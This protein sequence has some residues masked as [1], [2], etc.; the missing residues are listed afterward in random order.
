M[1]ALVCLAIVPDL[2]CLVIGRQPH[3]FCTLELSESS[4]DMNT[5]RDYNLMVFVFCQVAD[6]Q[7]LSNGYTS[8]RE[9]V[10]PLVIRDERADR[11][12][13]K[14]HHGTCPKS[15]RGWNGGMPKGNDY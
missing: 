9:M 14:T 6:Y 2:V 7:F 13:G 11:K 12:S 8:F 15:T 4:D 10:G 1:T 5:V 3:V